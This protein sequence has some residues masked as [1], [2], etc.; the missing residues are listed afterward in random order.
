MPPTRAAVYHL[1]MNPFVNAHLAAIVESNRFLETV[2]TSPLGLYSDVKMLRESLPTELAAELSREENLERRKSVAAMSDSPLELA[3][4]AI[5][6]MSASVD[7]LAA[8]VDS[9][10]PALD[11]NWVERAR[12]VL[13]RA[14][15]KVG[16][17][18]RAQESARRLRGLYVIVDPEA[19]RG[20]PVPEVAE[21]A[22]RGGASVVQLRDKSRDKGEVLPDAQGLMALCEEYGALFVVNDDA[23]LA[24]AVGAHALHVGQTD[25]PVSAARAVLSPAQLIGTSNGTL[26]E[27]RQSRAGGADYIA[28]GAIFATTTMGKSGR[29]ALG[30]DAIAQVRAAVDAPVVAIGGIDLANVADVVKAGADSVCVVSAVTFADDPEDAARGL[31]DAMNAAL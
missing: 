7:A 28:V 20:R 17:E 23:D 13:A 6:S 1:P 31:V 15:H 24:R 2:V 4:S 3:L 21:A 26:D 22:L 18:L 14:G 29:T 9:D 27:A 30:V 5:A 12:R 19:T 8:C 11:A 10:A 25:L 16:G